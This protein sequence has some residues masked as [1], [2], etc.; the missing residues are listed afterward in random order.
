MAATDIILQRLPPSGLQSAEWEVRTRR[1]PFG[2]CR[3]TLSANT[4]TRNRLLKLC[5]RVSNERTRIIGL[6]KIAT[7]YFNTEIDTNAWIK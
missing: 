7:T 5:V 3:N 2:I 4:I 6:N 1:A